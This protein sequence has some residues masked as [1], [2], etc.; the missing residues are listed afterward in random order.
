MIRCGEPG[1]GQRS[2]IDAAQANRVAKRQSPKPGRV[3]VFS[4]QS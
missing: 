2:G 4:K 1:I 3:L